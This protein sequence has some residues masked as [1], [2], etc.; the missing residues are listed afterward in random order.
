MTRSGLV[1]AML[2]TTAAAWLSHGTLAVSSLDGSRIGLLPGS[3][4]AWATSLVAGAAVVGV[5]RAGASLAPIWLLAF[6][7]FPW[8]PLPVPAAFLVWSGPIRWLIWTAVVIAMLVT[9]FADRD[10]RQRLAHGLPVLVALVRDRP[11]WTAGA[12]AFAIF[13]FTVWQVSPS[14]PGG[15][16]P[17]Y[18]VITQSLLLD[19]DLKIENNHTRGDYQ[20]YYAGRLAPHYVR[21]GANGE[22][23]SIHAP[24]VSA[25]VAP[26]FAIGGYRGA[27]L[28]LLV[29]AACGSALAWHVAWL[30]SGQQSAAWFGWAAV[31]LSAT[32]IFHSFAVYPDA[33]G[34]V[35]ALTGVWALLRADDERRTG[36]ARVWPWFLHGAALACLPW[37]H[38]RFA[39]LAGSLGALV[40]LRL[41]STK[42][43]AGKAVA[44]LSIPAVSA[45][46]WM[47]FFVAIYGVADPSAPY[48]TGRDFSIAFIP[49]GLTGLLFDQRFGLLAN[50]PVL[51]VGVAGLVM[52][53]RMPKTSEPPLSP[54]RADRRLAIEL[55][56]VMV[57]YLL[58]ATSYAMW[59]AGSSAPARF[60]SPAVLILAI[61]CAVAWQL[62]RNRGTRVIA[63]GSL[64]LTGF[65]SS[66]LVVVGGGR[67]AYNSRESTAQWLDWASRLTSLGEGMPVWY[68][69]REAGFSA[70]VVVWMA[71]LALAW[72]CAR[73]IAAA[74]RFRDRGRLL[75]V[76]A[77]VY[78]AAA[79]LAVTTVWRIHRVDGVLAAPAELDM[80]RV[81][82]AEPRAMAFQVSPPRR[83]ATAR[84]LEMLTLESTVRS[85]VRTVRS[86]DP[87][88]SVFPSMP[89]GRY[90]VR[91]EGGGSSGWL[92]LG[93][94]QDQFAL[95]SE[96]LVW[97]QA[98]IEV[99]LPV[100]VRA[101]IVRGD[102]D[103][104]RAI[105]K[106]IVEPLSIV[107]SSARL[108]D[109]VA[110][111]AVKYEG[112]AVFFLDDRSFADPESFWIGGSRQSTFVVQ[113]D[114]PRPSIELLLRNAPVDNRLTL[115]A[116]QWREELTLA[117]GEERRVQ[118]P[119][120]PGQHAALVTATTT[121]GFRPSEATP[122]SKDDRF[123]GVWVKPVE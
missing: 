45:I 68:R 44:F 40:L 108:T 5:A 77:A 74:E 57:P 50:A 92:M 49:G 42:N 112:A 6:L 73:R 27:V 76:V 70:D 121:S 64:A 71:A 60:A 7:V 38:S 81:V 14:V 88:V 59:W 22:I 20:V 15:D 104:R 3:P 48:G 67:L 4:F 99:E 25:L 30:A 69:D 66:V 115:E 32:T 107:R 31:T 21:R 56:F 58:T 84:L 86:N 62:I 11:R 114:R 17:H 120:A 8:L 98:P 85:Q 87:T 113:S 2:L 35:I 12:L 103:A 118:V 117:P 54:G 80:L 36:E 116:G 75:T 105:R 9:V 29:I 47:G 63:A 102:E 23:Y 13:A 61:P 79:M 34:G 39:L 33:V 101:L 55:L 91:L 100:A 111:R 19:G 16:E 18:L 96:A 26:A 82:A 28:F 83:L 106:V 52:M 24:G 43:P 90:R 10:R 94:G 37:L 109:L 65:L 123:L 72:W 41:S 97:P 78:L 46:S 89:A 1:A 110:R 51:A 53:L 119:V 93:I 95:R 122:G